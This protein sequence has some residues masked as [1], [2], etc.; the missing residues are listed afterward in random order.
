VPNDDLSPHPRRIGDCRH[1]VTKEFCRWDHSVGSCGLDVARL[2]A[3]KSDQWN[4]CIVQRHLGAAEPPMR[5]SSKDATR[6]RLDMA[7][8]SLGDPSDGERKVSE[9]R[10]WP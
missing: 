3:C 8:K 10:H 7:T 5:P 4:E 1:G 9:R 2:S 6:R